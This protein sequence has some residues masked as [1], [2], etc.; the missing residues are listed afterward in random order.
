MYTT[1]SSE[2]GQLGNG[3]TGEHFIT[4]NKLAFA[5]CN[6]FTKRTIFCHAPDEKLHFNSEMSKVVSLNEDVRIQYVACGKHHTLAVEAPSQRTPRVFS[7]G[8]GDYGCLG[9]GVQ[10]PEYYPRLI[11]ILQGPAFVGQDY[12]VAAGPHCSL[13][14]TPMGR[15]YYWG[16]HRPVG[17]AVMRPQLLDELA[18]NEHNVQHC[19][20]GAQTVVCCT[21]FKTICWGN[22]PH[23]DL[24]LGVNRKSS[25]KPTF[26]EVMDNLH[27]MNLACGLGHTLW[28]VRNENAKDAS[29]IG[30]L[31]K[32]E[33]ED[34]QELVD[35]IAAGKK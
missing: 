33:E 32:L 17:E 16:R 8:C 18:Q 20:S 3:E 35:S 12:R 5:N 11:G 28:V 15:V 21:S 13:L 1:G 2:F 9:H 31:N 19:A 6:L 4:A 27:V 30:K 14:Q 24:G 22:G 23:G 7:W 26:V 29:I 10:A 34:V 25:A